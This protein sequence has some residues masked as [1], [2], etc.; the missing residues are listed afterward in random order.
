MP[1]PLVIV[2]GKNGQLGWEINQLCPEYADKYEFVFSGRED[3]DLLK[4]ETVPA[5]FEKYRPKYF[6]NC[7]AYTAVDKAETERESAYNSNAVSVGAIASECSKIDCTLINISTDYVFDGNGIAPYPVSTKANPVNYYGHTKW[8][9]EQLAKENNP[10][11]IVIRTSWVF[12]EH[13]NNFVKTMLRLMKERTELKVVSDQTG[14]PTYAADLA[15]AILAIINRQESGNGHYGTYHYS[16]TGIISWFDFAVKIRELAKL[17]C[18]LLPIPSSAYPTPARRP[19]YSA[20]DTSAIA[21]DFNLVLLP[22][23]SSLANC[24]KKIMQPE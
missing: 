13:G 15:K 12:S 5:F 17:N 1:K 8:M 21:E 9:G 10:K 7:A 14:S 2:T 3:L 20:M 24:L 16:N 22:W 23:E 18:T 11:T 4:P 19:V 6:I